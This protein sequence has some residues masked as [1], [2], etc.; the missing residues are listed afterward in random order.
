MSGLEFAWTISSN[1]H[2]VA[3]MLV[4]SICLY[5]FVRPYLMYRKTAIYAG[6]VY[7]TVMM[8]MYIIPWRFDNFVSYAASVFA[9]FIVMYL[10]ERRNAEQ[11][12]FLAVTFFSIR[13]LNIAM[14]GEIDSAL[15]RVTV[16]RQNIAARPWLQF[17]IYAG[18]EILNVGIGMF[19]IMISIYLLNKTFDYK[20]ANMTKKELFMLIMP[21]ISVMTEYGI[22][23]LYQGIY[24]HDTGNSLIFSH[25]IYGYFRFLHYLISI[26]SILVMVIVFQNL[27]ARQL[28][29][30]GKKLLQ[31]QITDMKK[32]IGEVEKLYQDIRLMR[33][34]MGNHIQTIEHLLAKNEK[35]Q[36]AGYTARLR[37]E[38]KDITIGI[39][40]GNPITD[41]ILLEKKNEAQKRNIKFLCDF[42]YPEGTNAD[43][44]D[45]SVILNNALDNCLES[46]NGVMPYINISSFRKNNIF[47][48]VIS[49]SFEGKIM[50]DDETEL[51]VSAKVEA[52]HGLGLANIR[53]V[54]QKYLGDI[55]FE[56]EEG[57]IVLTA[58]LQLE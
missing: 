53:R 50:L 16:M 52:G 31:S 19:F 47:I 55:L 27:K 14:A 32:H 40:S 3:V 42:H 15:I 43:A 20:K 10:E 4:T 29:S 51:P 23:K 12:I 57:K 13:W 37:E 28:E 22:W 56:H 58:M 25:G 38:W 11:K 21:S 34:D 48:I 17:G 1:V 39:K 5:Y 41:V 33:H 54:A 9:A 44:F 36:A 46:V 45:I 35:E 49:N 24:E 2:I 6:T 26:I 7:F 8:V 30:A 18:L